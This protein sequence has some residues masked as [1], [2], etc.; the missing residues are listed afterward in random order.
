MREKMLRGFCASFIEEKTQ[1]RFPDASPEYI[2]DIVIC[3]IGQI[4][5]PHM[6]QWYRLK[7]GR[8]FD[9]DFQ[10]MFN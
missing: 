8:D 1:K 3:E 6:L 9:T 2:R 7:M 4:S 5:F 10:A